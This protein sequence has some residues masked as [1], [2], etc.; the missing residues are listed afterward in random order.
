MPSAI[1]LQ[2]IDLERNRGFADRELKEIRGLIEK[3]YDRIIEA[4]HEHCG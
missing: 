4:W 3:H 2:P 1:W